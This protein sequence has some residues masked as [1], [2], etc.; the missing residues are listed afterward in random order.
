MPNH[1][2][3]QLDAPK[4]VIDSLAGKNGEVDFSSVIPMPE[5]LEGDTS[6][7]S[8]VDAAKFA[9][10][11]GADRPIFGNHKPM[12]MSDDHFELLIRYMRCL[13]QYGHASWYEWSIANWGTKWNAYD[14]KR[15]SDRK[16]RFQTAWNAPL[17]VIEALSRKFPEADLRIRWADEDDGANTGDMWCKAGVWTGKR[18]ENNS[19][20]AWALVL[21]LNYDGVVPSHLR[22][23]DDGTMEY[24]EE[25]EETA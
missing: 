2:T 12:E 13:K 10:R 21:M 1:I 20:S 9:M 17:A 8:I 24:V 6:T 19:S 4:E 25:V 11:I 5:L 23:K 18:I 7:P 16:I 3:C 22:M 14:I 15:H